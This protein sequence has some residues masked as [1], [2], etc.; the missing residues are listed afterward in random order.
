MYK[1]VNLPIVLRIFLHVCF[2][3][4]SAMEPASRRQSPYN[5]STAGASGSSKFTPEVYT[6]EGKGQA[7]VGTFMLIFFRRGSLEPQTSPDLKASSNTE[8]DYMEFQ[9]GQSQDPWKIFIGVIIANRHH[10][11]VYLCGI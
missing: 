1:P 9:L 7:P 2:S 8:P 4:M 3:A 5:L 10:L 11:I 6:N